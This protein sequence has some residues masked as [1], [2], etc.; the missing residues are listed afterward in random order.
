[1]ILQERFELFIQII[2]FLIDVLTKVDRTNCQALIFPFPFGPCLMT[3]S[4]YILPLLGHLANEATHLE[5][6]H[7]FVKSQLTDPPLS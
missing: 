5:C 6:P 2:H 4:Y 7:T 1:M 3:P